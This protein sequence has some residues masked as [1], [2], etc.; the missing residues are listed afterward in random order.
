M[1]T[2]SAPAFH[3]TPIPPLPPFPPYLPFVHSSLPPHLP[4]LPFFPFTH[5]SLPLLPYLPFLHSLPIPPHHVPPSPF[6]GPHDF[7][8]SRVLDLNQEFY[9][10]HK[11]LGISHSQNVI[12][13]MFMLFHT[14]YIMYHVL[15]RRK[16]LIFVLILISVYM[17]TYALIENS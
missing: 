3:L 10:S 16:E 7:L 1:L 8:G 13:F 12:M 11:F 17:H 6:L 4:F 2:L 9:T 15:K 5:S 14:T